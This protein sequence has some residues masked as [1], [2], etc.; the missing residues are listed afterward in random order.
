MERYKSLFKELWVYI[1]IVVIVVGLKL[2]VVAPIR[3]NGSS[4]EKTL[5]DKDIMI[6]DQ[7]SYRFSDIE[8]FDIVVVEHNGEH[9]IKRVIGLPGEKVAYK[10]NK[11][12][13]NGKQV[14]EDFSHQLTNDFDEVMVPKGKYFVLGDNRSN[15]TDSRVL[16]FFSRSDVKGKTSLIIFPF[17]RFGIKK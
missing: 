3:V 8:R 16:G 10:D 1:T 17:K 12:Y 6:L 7:I 4:M 5:Y 15:S 14:V 13:I 11:L 2:F 9:L